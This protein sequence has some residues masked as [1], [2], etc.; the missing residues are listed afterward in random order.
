[1]TKL[2]DLT[3]ARRKAVSPI[4]VIETMDLRLCYEWKIVGDGG[5]VYY[6]RF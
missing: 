2:R 4:I 5:A 1:M 6:C 3:A